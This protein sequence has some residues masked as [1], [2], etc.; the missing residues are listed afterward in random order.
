MAVLKTEDYKNLFRK[1]NLISTDRD[2]VWASIIVSLS[3]RLEALGQAEGKT[4]NSVRTLATLIGELMGNADG[5]VEETVEGD[6]GEAG[7]TGAATGTAG[8]AGGGSVKTP[9]RDGDA[10]YSQPFPAGVSSTVAGG[11]AAPVG[12]PPVAAAAGPPSK[13]GP[14]EEA[15]EDLTPNAG[16]GP[17][18]NAQPI[19]KNPN[20]RGANA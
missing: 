19:P 3:D 18:V 16:G 2:K 11:G 14:V 4:R 7:M 15:A 17:A 10:R 20:G 1:Y 9:S 5:G 6:V 8:G 12:G 13:T